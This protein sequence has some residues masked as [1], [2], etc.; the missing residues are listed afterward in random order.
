MG[1]QGMIRCPSCDHANRADRRYCAFISYRH[2]D[3]AHEG[4]RWAEWLHR[5][6]ISDVAFCP[7]HDHG[8]GVAASADVQRCWQNTI[9][10]FT[11]LESM[12]WYGHSL[13]RLLCQEFG[14]GAEAKIH[15]LSGGRW[16][17]IRFR[18]WAPRKAP[19]TPT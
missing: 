14:S 1:A 11:P 16:R 15:D 6:A 12:R 13:R 9:Q 10:Y 7:G 8:P 5:A 19:A 18:C 4:R 17:R 2:A 3:N